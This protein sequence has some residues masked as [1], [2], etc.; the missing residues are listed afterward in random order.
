MLTWVDSI[1]LLEFAQS[2]RIDVTDH[3]GS[4][5][6]VWC[7]FSLSRHRLLSV[8]FQSDG[9]DLSPGLTILSLAP[10]PKAKNRII[11]NKHVSGAMAFWTLNNTRFWYRLLVAACFPVG[12]AR[13]AY[14][15]LTNGGCILHAAEYAKMACYMS[16]SCVV[17]LWSLPLVLQ[18]LIHESISSHSEC[19]AQYSSYWPGTWS[20]LAQVI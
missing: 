1:D 18:G 10:K 4:N 15:S 17:L 9:V 19:I 12:F 3:S 13:T 14:G 5:P 7:S 6:R 16:L 8:A 11:Q 2:S 20:I